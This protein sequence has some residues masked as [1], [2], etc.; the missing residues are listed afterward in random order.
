MKPVEAFRFLALTQDNVPGMVQAAATYASRRDLSAMTSY[1]QFLVDQAEKTPGVLKDTPFT[2]TLPANLFDKPRV[3]SMTSTAVFLEFLP[4]ACSAVQH[5]VFRATEDGL[6]LFGKLLELLCGHD[7]P[8]NLRNGQGGKIVLSLKREAAKRIGEPRVF[9]LLLATTAPRG[10]DHELMALALTAGNFVGA[11]RLSFVAP[12]RSSQHA[13]GIWRQDIQPREVEGSTRAQDFYRNEMTRRVLYA[14]THDQATHV[15]FFLDA[16]ERNH[17]HTEMVTELRQDL[18]AAY[19]RYCRTELRA[20]WSEATIHALAGKQGLRG[21]AILIARLAAELDGYSPD[22]IWEP[23]RGNNWECRGNSEEDDA[24]EAMSADFVYQVVSSHCTPLLRLIPSLIRLAMEA[25]DPYV[26]HVPGFDDA[27]RGG[28][29]SLIRGEL[30]ASAPYPHFSEAHF[31]G[32]IELLLA[33]GL[34]I[35]YRRFRG[36]CRTALE[37][38]AHL[39]LEAI[40]RRLPPLLHHGA[41]PNL[42]APPGVSARDLC[43]DPDVRAV[44]E[45]IE[46]RVVSL[47]PIATV[48]DAPASVR[49][50]VARFIAESAACSTSSAD[51]Q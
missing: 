40:K 33:A 36:Q 11:A 17:G 29:D 35:N 43:R 30:R 23:I 14:V 45:E 41:N 49:D 26:A 3:V 37:E 42:T 51:S 39:D 28:F 12:E 48:P 50:A 38:L 20:G 1:L 2:C 13:M 46:S 4:P 5:Q 16:L 21:K 32:T 47:R 7:A 10:S 22:A 27:V 18:I 6:D 15:A 44:W 25:S 19:L 8:L 31:V 34:D 24:H 9:D